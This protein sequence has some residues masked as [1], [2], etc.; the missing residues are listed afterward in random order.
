MKIIKGNINMKLK[1][2]NLYTFTKSKFIWTETENLKQA[3]NNFN[4]RL[5]IDNNGYNH[6][7]LEYVFNPMRVITVDKS[8]DDYTSD[9]LGNRSDDEKIISFNCNKLEN[10]ILKELD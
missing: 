3:I 8:D 4:R 1:R 6:P 5:N 10:L 2:Y 7:E 9:E